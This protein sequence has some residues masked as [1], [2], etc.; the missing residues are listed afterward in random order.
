MQK[1]PDAKTIE[2]VLKQED[3]KEHNTNEQ[4]TETGERIPKRRDNKAEM[5]SRN[6]RTLYWNSRTYL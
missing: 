2:N 5:L 1:Q 4:N 3:I 6:R